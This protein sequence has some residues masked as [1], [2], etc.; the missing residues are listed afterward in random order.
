MSEQTKRTSKRVRRNRSV[1]PPLEPSKKTR[2]NKRKDNQAAEQAPTEEQGTAEGPREGTEAAES[3]PQAVASST[4]TNPRKK[5]GYNRREADQT[6]NRRETRDGTT[7]TGRDSGFVD[8][9]QLE[10]SAQE[11]AQ[12]TNTQQARANRAPMIEEDDSSTQGSTQSLAWDNYDLQRRTQG[13]TRPQDT[14]NSQ[15]TDEEEDETANR[16]GEPGGTHSRREETDPPAEDDDDVFEQEELFSPARNDGNPIEEDEEDLF[17]PV[18]LWNQRSDQLN[19]ERTGTNI[20]YNQLTEVISESETENEDP[21]ARLLASFNST[22]TRPIRPTTPTTQTDK[23]QIPQTN[24]PTTNR[25][26]ITPTQQ[27]RNPTPPQ[28]RQATNMA[29]GL[30]KFKAPPTFSGKTGEDPADWID[31][32]EVLA[33]YNRWSDDDKRLNFG[34]YMEGPARQWFQC[35]TPPTQWADTAAV[36]AAQGVARTPA[37]VGMRSVFTKEFLQDSYAGYQENK[38]RNRKQGANEPAAEYYYEVMNLCRLMDPNMTEAAKIHH[39]YQGLKRTL[40]EK[41][42]VLQPKTCA[43]FLA[44]IR[45]HTE[46]TDIAQN[47]GWAV[48]TLATDKEE[49]RV[50]AI[51]REQQSN[52]AEEEPSLKQLFE[53]VQQL[54][55][56][57]IAIKKRPP[58]RDRPDNKGPQYNTQSNQTTTPQRTA[59]GRP[60]CFYCKEDG[61]IKRYCPKKKIDDETQ[62]NTQ[63][64]TTVALMS[65]SDDE[66]DKEI[67]LLK[68]DVAQLLV[69]NVTIGKD[70]AEREIEAVIDTGA[71]VSIVKWLIFGASIRR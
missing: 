42:W 45:R 63:R 70:G 6:R 54:Q 31:R 19:P 25:P 1:P 3:P 4:Q 46:A 71:A 56:E 32:Y 35:L 22:P 57:I 23:S 10:N 7:H 28:I 18:R 49:A 11:P 29:A 17:T 5:C 53:V 62:S 27:N 40:V 51:G 59:D 8:R 64:N 37:V 21:T 14:R 20:S 69:E 12:P 58:R 66:C 39:L 47:Q 2:D 65:T 16:T 9:S 26:N 60:I 52:K 34:I 44:T 13:R 30:L 55:G 67:P 38:L 50:A 43:E 68:I 41:I 61:H 48:H 33:D 15:P 24:Q 36:A